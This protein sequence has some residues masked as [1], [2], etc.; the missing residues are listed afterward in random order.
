MAR[1]G[2]TDGADTLRGT[3]GGDVIFGNGGDDVL[4]GNGGWDKLYGGPGD[5]VLRGGDGE[6][7]L[8]GGPGN[9]TYIG[10]RGGPDRYV[11][12]DVPKVGYTSE[13]IPVFKI[14]DVLDFSGIDADWTRD[15]NQRFRWLGEGDFEGQPGDL[16]YRHL[17]D[18][19]DSTTRFYVDV[20]GNSQADMIVTIQNGHYRF[21]QGDFLIL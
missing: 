21:Q 3:S 13:V 14:G 7:R 16:I 17:G 12:T 10:G 19:L 1:I 4:I 9:D 2:G 15:G 20:D 6:D 5:D 18:G 8:Q 11:F